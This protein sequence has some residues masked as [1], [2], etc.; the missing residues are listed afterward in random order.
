MRPLRV[1][2]A[3]AVNAA[4]AWPDGNALVTGRRM[5]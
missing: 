1:S 4:V 2:S 3:A 5:P